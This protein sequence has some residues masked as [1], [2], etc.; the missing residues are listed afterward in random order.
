[1]QYAIFNNQGPGSQACPELRNVLSLN[2][3]QGISNFEYRS[4]SPSKASFEIHHSVFDI[5]YSKNIWICN[6]QYSTIKDPVAQHLPELRKALSLKYQNKEYR[7]SNIN[8][9]LR[10]KR[11]SKFIIQ[12]FDIQYSK[13]IQYAIRNI[14]QSRTR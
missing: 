8:R 12:W 5:R 4:E 14:Q 11:R 1:M 3:E 6:T 2:I 13:N 10:Q 9:G 7:I